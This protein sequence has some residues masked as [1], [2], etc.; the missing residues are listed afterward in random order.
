LGGVKPLARRKVLTPKSVGDVL[1]ELGT[2]Y[3]DARQ[4][5]TDTLDAS[6]LAAILTAIRQTVEAS[7]LETRLRELERRMENK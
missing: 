5:R 3:R 7:D 2:L 1:T 4:G 6:R